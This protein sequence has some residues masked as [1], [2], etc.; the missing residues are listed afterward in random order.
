MLR[1]ESFKGLMGIM[2][3]QDAKVLGLGV[4]GYAAINAAT[5]MLSKEPPKD[6]TDGV[7]R[8]F[9]RLPNGKEVLMIGYET[10]KDVMPT[11]GM[12]VLG[13]VLCAGIAKFN[14]KLF[15]SRLLT[16]DSWAAFNK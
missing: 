13:T 11:V 10:A 7:S 12:V 6:M 1:T 5:V 9:Y 3:R 4:V 15:T 8:F 2:A 14:P 16:G